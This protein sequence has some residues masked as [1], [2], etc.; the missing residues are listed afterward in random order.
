VASRLRQRF[1]K[2]CW[3][4]VISARASILW[5]LV[6]QT[7]LTPSNFNVPATLGT[8]VKKEQQR[9]RGVESWLLQVRIGD[10]L[11]PNR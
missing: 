6:L 3:K 11:C 7:A 1:A 8:S 2:P 9:D 10:D 4:P 5:W